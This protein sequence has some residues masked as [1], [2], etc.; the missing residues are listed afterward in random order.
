MVRGDP[1]H[2]ASLSSIAPPPKLE[3]SSIMGLL[4]RKQG[5]FVY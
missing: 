2:F 3:L 1:Y 4:K 5:I